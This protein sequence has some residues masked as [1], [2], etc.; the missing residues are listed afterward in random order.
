MRPEFPRRNRDAA[1]EE[2]NVEAWTPKTELGRKVKAGD[3]SDIGQILRHGKKIMEPEITEKLLPGLESDLINIGQ[4]KG[5]FGGGKRRALKQTQKKTEDGSKIHFSALAVVGN[6]NGYVGMGLG[7]SQETIPARDKALRK[8]KMNVIEIA[9]GC[10]SWQCT[11]GKPHSIPFAVTGR[12]G[13]VRVRLMPAPRGTG[14]ACEKE[15]RK[16]LALA[17][18]KD[19]WSKIMGQCRQKGNLM[20]ATEG[21]LRML[22]SRK[23]RSIDGSKVVH[24]RIEG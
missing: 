20:A 14:L 15:L 8:A 19:I 23:L 5:K 4:S 11:C 2:F 12:K 13:S 3:I 17:G 9:R 22:S 6:K 16:V 1:R 24:G 7:S 21:A 10:G 18:I